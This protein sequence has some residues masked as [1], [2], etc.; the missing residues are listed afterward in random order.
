MEMQRSPLS[1][2]LG[3]VYIARIVNQRWSEKMTFPGN[4]SLPRSIICGAMLGLAVAAPAVAAPSFAMPFDITAFGARDFL[5]FGSIAL[6][7]VA[8][9]AKVIR[10][11]HHSEPTPQ[12]PDL[13]WWKNPPPNPQP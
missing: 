2:V 1:P 12:G 10:D 8:L 9:T 7:I 3:A 5:L 11:R 6:L 4:F 13:R